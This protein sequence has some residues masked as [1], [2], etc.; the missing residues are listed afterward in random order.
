[1]SNEANVTGKTDKFDE[2]GRPQPR[3]VVFG[4]SVAKHR[5]IYP[6]PDYD[7]VAN[8]FLLDGLPVLSALVEDE[9]G[10]FT[11]FVLEELHFRVDDLQEESG[12]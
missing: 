1:M 8:L 9:V 12:F 4:Q 7:G 11:F 6:A 10:Y 3:V 2:P 5:L